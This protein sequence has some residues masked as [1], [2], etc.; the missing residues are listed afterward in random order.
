MLHLIRTHLRSLRW[1]V[2]KTKYKSSL[3]LT[4]NTSPIKLGIDLIAADLPAKDVRSY[5]KEF[6]PNSLVSYVLPSNSSALSSPWQGTACIL[7][8]PDEIISYIMEIVHDLYTSWQ[9]DLRTKPFTVPG[10][11]DIFDMG[12][13]ASVLSSVSRRFR[14]IA[15]DT[16]YLWS[17]IVV[18]TTFPCELFIK[19]SASAPLYVTYDFK[20]YVNDT[21]NDIVFSQRR[22]WKALHIV[23]D[24][25]TMRYIF[26][27]DDLSFPALESLSVKYC[28]AFGYFRTLWDVN[29][30][31]K[32]FEDGLMLGSMATNLV[33]LHIR[34]ELCDPRISLEF[35]KQDLMTCL[36]GCKVLRMLSLSWEFKFFNAWQM[37]HVDAYSWASHTRRAPQPVVLLPSL[38]SLHFEHDSA[39]PRVL[40]ALLKGIQMPMLSKLWITEN[41][42]EHS[43]AHFSLVDLLEDLGPLDSVRTLILDLKCT[44]KI[45]EDFKTL[46]DFI[47]QHMPRVSELIIDRP[48]KTMDQFPDRS[49]PFLHLLWFQ[50]GGFAI[51]SVLKYA[52][53]RMEYDGKDGKV[54]PLTLKVPL[55]LMKEDINRH[56]D[57]IMNAIE[58]N[59]IICHFYI[60]IWDFWFKRFQ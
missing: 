28:G 47:E 5:I 49:L 48:V 51:D 29:R 36:S 41:F 24:M 26:N 14:C 3:E 59:L 57:D 55:K 13:I 11:Q 6:F 43:S 27:Q 8:L 34:M 16:P 54:G 37:Y 25:S 38:E 10:R 60:S 31:R 23:D 58:D 35:T 2:K 1:R 50:S 44:G 12:G 22:R 21:Q 33:S 4:V 15:L 46:F 40:G 18:R 9:V 52:K 39:Y 45:F 53:R 56:Y 7:E 30:T 17:T 42:Y 19:R 32:I 20:H